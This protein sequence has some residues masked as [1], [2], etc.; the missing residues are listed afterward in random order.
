MKMGWKYDLLLPLSPCPSRNGR[1]TRRLRRGGWAPLPF[2]NLPLATC[3]YSSPSPVV[4]QLSCPCLTPFM[5]ISR[6]AR[7]CT[8]APFPCTTITSTQL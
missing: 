1:G 4:V 6:S 8:S 5:V 2:P 7:A 3:P